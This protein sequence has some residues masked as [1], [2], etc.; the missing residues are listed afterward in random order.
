LHGEPR[1][2]LRHHEVETR[3]TLSSRS[4]E[5][6]RV[7]RTRS[8]D[9]SRLDRVR[10]DDPAR[11][12]PRASTSQRRPNRFRNL[13]HTAGGACDR[14]LPPTPS[15]RIPISIHHWTE[16]DRTAIRGDDRL[17]TTDARPP[18]Q[19]HVEPRGAAFYFGDRA[20]YCGCMARFTA[21]HALSG[22]GDSVATE[23]PVMCSS[24]IVR[25]GVFFPSWIA[26][27]TRLTSRRRSFDAPR[28]VGWTLRVVARPA[29]TAASA[30]LVKR[31][32]ARIDQGRLP[33]DDFTGAALLAK[34]LSMPTRLPTALRRSADASDSSPGPARFET[35][36][37]RPRRGSHGS[38]H[39]VSQR[40]ARR[41]SSPHAALRRCL[42][43]MNARGERPRFRDFA[44]AIRGP[45]SFRSGGFG[46]LGYP[47]DAALRFPSALH[48][49]ASTSSSDFCRN[50]DRGH[51]P[52]KA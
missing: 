8:S 33:S 48:V 6:A 10:S 18:C 12:R 32:A 30:R 26:R 35:G 51:E 3:R 23:S 1:S 15:K 14:R 22:R 20:F 29:E 11:V 7:R 49:P 50:F 4:S 41:A 47:V 31:R 37:R 25:A 34:T 16:F 45:T 24:R 13:D 28:R 46:L 43:G 39:F 36:F 44:A 5:S 38:V 52:S 21:P 27:P 19:S 17:S 2:R 9:V 40:R 42:D